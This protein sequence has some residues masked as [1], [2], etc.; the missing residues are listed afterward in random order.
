MKDLHLL[1][2]LLTVVLAGGCQPSSQPDAPADDRQADVYPIVDAS[3]GQL[4][5]ASRN[6]DWLTGEEAASFVEEGREYRLF[7][8]TDTLGTHTGGSIQPAGEICTNPSL[9]VDNLPAG[10]SD[11]IGVTGSWEI[12]PRVS[13]V[14]DT[15]QQIYRERIADHLEDHDIQVSSVELDQV[16]R[17]DLE[18]DGVEEVL[19]VS[20]R[21]RGSET[22]AMAG[23]YGVILLRRVIDGEVRETP[24]EAEYYP[25]ECIGECAPS[26]FRVSNVL[27]LNADGILEVVTGFRYSEGRGKRIHA[28]DGL[29]SEVVLS[30]RCGV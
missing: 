18:G 29:Q 20:N 14:Q 15:T 24:L 30:W 4:F 22:M 3:R 10:R 6:G 11:V 16:L 27:D 9:S 12:L 26:S 13:V 19:I 25:E 7:G 5:G 1:I 21:L 17:I 8:L 23:D 2:N 28:V